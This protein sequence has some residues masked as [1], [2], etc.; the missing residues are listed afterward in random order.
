MP[1]TA[2]TEENQMEYIKRLHIAQ[3][4]MHFR[5]M[6][7]MATDSPSA[8]KAHGKLADAIDNSTHYNEALAIAGS[9]VANFD[10]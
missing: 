10:Y 5:A 8:H 9:I 6:G 2:T 4:A 3:L 1:T 7:G